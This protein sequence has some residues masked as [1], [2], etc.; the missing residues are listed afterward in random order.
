MSNTGPTK[1]R[2]WTQVVK[3]KQFLL[4]LRHPP[5]YSYMYIYRVKS[6]KKGKDPLSFE[7]W[8]FHNGQ[9]Y[10]DYDRRIFAAMTST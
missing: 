7:M 10:R 1:N 9:P 4:V 5:Y 3:G 6:D 8:I 2:N